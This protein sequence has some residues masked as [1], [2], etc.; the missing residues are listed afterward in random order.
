VI[1]PITLR[2]I[3]GS[4]SPKNPD[5]VTTPNKIEKA[6]AKVKT[7]VEPIVFAIV[8]MFIFICFARLIDLIKK[9]IDCARTNKITI[10]ATI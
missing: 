4:G 2:R 8:Y 6:G 3:Q 1:A 7:V 5:R 9:K 10:P